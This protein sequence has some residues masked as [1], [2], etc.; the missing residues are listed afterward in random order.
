MSSLLDQDK[1]TQAWILAA[2]AHADQFI[3]GL[4]LPYIV[5]VGNVT[6]EVLT[7]FASE[8]EPRN[9]NLAVLCALLHDTLEDTKLQVERIALEFGPD[10]VA[11]VKAL[12]KDRTMGTKRE[13][14]QDSLTRI[15][16]QPK[17]I[18]M[19]KLADRIVN[20]QP[21]PLHWNYEKIQAYHSEAMLIHDTLREGSAFLA[22]RLTE[23]IRYY[24]R[25]VTLTPANADA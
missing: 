12:T 3:P 2:E 24:A 25:Y 8:D 13:Q 16:E 6:M 1:L 7:A 22:K 10:V 17:E 11:G 9:R 20:L 21:P 4:S 19:V 15:R 14:M 23:K 18:W 5:H